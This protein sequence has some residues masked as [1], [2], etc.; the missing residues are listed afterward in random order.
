MPKNNAPEPMDDEAIVTFLMRKIERSLNDESGGVSDVRQHNF[1]RYYGKPYGDERE[2]YSS[3]ITR[4]TFEAVEWALPGPLRV[5][6]SGDRAVSFDADGPEDEDQ[7][8]Q[9]TD[10]ANHYLLKENNGFLL[11]Y[12][13]LKDILMYPN[14]YVKAHVEEKTETEVE[15]YTGLPIS[16]LTLLAEHPDVEVLEQDSEV[17]TIEGMTVEL[18]DVKVRVTR[19]T[20]KLL[21]QNIP[22][23]ELLVDDGLTTIDLD[24]ASF[25]CHKV[26]KSISDLVAEGYDYDELMAVGEDRKESWNDERVNRLFYEEENPDSTDDDNTGHDRMLWVH[27]C[28]VKLDVDGDGLAE[29]RRIVL[30]GHEIFE[31]EEDS[32]QPFV[33]AAAIL[34]PHKHICMSYVESVQDLQ[35]VTSTVVRQLL[36]NVYKQ[37][38]RR[39]FLNENTITS[40][41]ETLDQILDAESEV[42]LVRG[43][44]AE[45]VQPEQIQP[46]VGELLEVT[47]FLRD[48]PQFRTGVAPNLSIDPNVLQQSTMGAFMGALEEANQRQE[49]LVRIFA[50][51]GVRPFMRKIHRLIRTHINVPKAL[52]IRGEWTNIDP[53]QW[54]ER[55]NLTVNVGLGHNSKEQKVQLL[56]QLLTMQKEAAMQNLSTPEHIFHTFDLLIQAVQLGEV[57]QFFTDPSKPVGVDP[58]TGHPIPWSPPQPP[59]DPNMLLAQAQSQALASK[60]EVEKF[61]AQSKAQLDAAK[62]QAEAQKTQAAVDKDRREIALRERGLEKELQEFRDKYAIDAATARADIVNRDA[63]TELKEAQRVKT[64]ADSGKAAA[65]TAKTRVEASDEVREA[66]DIIAHGIE[67]NEAEGEEG[68][69]TGEQESADDSTR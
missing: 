51:V 37:N 7:A 11:F 44:P 25:I 12:S 22:P 26:E 46:I 63:D 67:G 21:T 1:D 35:L 14:G 49:M 18:F 27:E 24:E 19:T 57:E 39:T 48:Q 41:N 16:E 60:A 10:V 53:S 54:R 43:N 59:P 3:F 6:T 36:D 68:S 30:I 23:E 61:E 8:K 20:R 40:D 64:L 58:Q 65:E 69:E 32:Y 52:K 17:K 38:I 34:I 66:K 28:Y 33:S 42:I 45:A 4:E 9:E 15:T 29:R 5:F 13:W 55:T 2:G 56:V 62:I 50:E 31:N 47:K